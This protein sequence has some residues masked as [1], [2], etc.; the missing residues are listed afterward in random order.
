MFI[1]IDY[2]LTFVNQNLFH[3]FSFRGLTTYYNVLYFNHDREREYK[4]AMK[5][6]GDMRKFKLRCG[7]VVEEVPDMPLS[8]NG[9]P[10]V[11]RVVIEGE[12]T[13]DCNGFVK[14]A[15]RRLQGEGTESGLPVGGGHGKAFDIVEEI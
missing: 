4:P 15:I 12:D 13:G 8:S 5:E 7:A 14:N 11:V 1:Y 9:Y 10:V 3:L 2:L 6:C